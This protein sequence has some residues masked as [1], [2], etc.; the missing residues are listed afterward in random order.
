MKPDQLRTELIREINLIPDTDLE[1]VHQLISHLRLSSEKQPSH[2]QNT[3]K[4]AGSWNDLTDEEFTDFLD[5]V[6]LRRQQ[7]FRDRNNHETFAD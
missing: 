5:E 3:L 6:T 4:F 1:K 2:L 7:S